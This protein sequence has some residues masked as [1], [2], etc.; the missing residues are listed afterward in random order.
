MATKRGKRPAAPLTAFWDTSAIVPL[1]CFQA[2]SSQARRT[3]RAYG[4]QVA[5]W[6]TVVEAVSVFNRLLRENALTVTGRQQALT[7]LDYL[8][9]RWHEMQPSAR[10]RS[11]AER[12]LAVHPLRAADALQL[13]AALEWCG[14]T[15]RGRRFVGADDALG[16]A[17]E[18]EGFSVIRLM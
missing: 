11:E 4:R 18:S 17:A 6:A 1:C 12:L 5:W 14:H 10:V 2:Q 8:R 13:A 9:Q 15:P 16:Q 3:A 7:R